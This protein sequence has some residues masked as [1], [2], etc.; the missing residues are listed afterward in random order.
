MA[1]YKY[2]E[3]GN[4]N[5]LT[6]L[7]FGGGQD[8]WAILLEL[9]YNKEF[10]QKYALN[11]LLVIMADTGWEHPKTYFF[12]AKAAD[13]CKEHGIDFTLITPDMGHHP[14]TW[15]TL[16]HNWETHNTIGSRAFAQTCTDNI[17][18]KP[19]Y[20]F[21]TAWLKENYNITTEKP[22]NVFKWFMAVHGKIRW[23]IGFA[24]GEDREKDRSS[25]P[26][27]RQNVVEYLFPL[28]EAGINRQAA[29][30]LIVG[31][32]HELPPPSNCTICFFM[33]LQELLWLFKNLP[34][35]YWHWVKL[36]R[37]KL[38]ASRAKGQ[39]ESKNHGPFPGRTIIQQTKVA[40]EKFGHW[41]DQQLNMY[42]MSHGHCVK[43]KH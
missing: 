30:D 4:S 20:S 29:Q 9:I 41:S 28:K 7:S 8:S 34:E 27:Y 32:G 14:R 19:Q 22:E 13:L 26:K 15:Q 25:D 2:I 21:V 33:S 12:T 43:S 1:V 37:N 24:D 6:I 36:E 38:N 17:K 31:Y 40:F 18:I 10:R 42:K 23:M 16:T 5:Q 35:H 39:P 3:P 11:K